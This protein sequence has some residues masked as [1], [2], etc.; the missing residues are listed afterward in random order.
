M[1]KMEPRVAERRRGVSEE[2]A[3]H[4]L[5]WIL[6]AIAVVGLVTVGFWLI[7]S[8]LLSVSTIT[9]EGA[10]KSDPARAISDLGVSVGMPTI[11]VNGGAVRLAVES[12]P[13]VDTAD[14]SV[15][16]PGSVVVTV[17]EHVPLAPATSGNEWM[18]LSADAAVLEPIKAPADDVFVV[19]IDVSGTPIGGSVD[20]PVVQG[21]LVFGSALRPDLAID[22]VMFA[23][24]GGLAAT[25]SGHIV[26]LGRPIELADK[27]LVLAALIDSGLPEGAE[28]NLIAPT[29]PAVTNPQPVVESEQ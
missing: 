25:V 14:V 5:R 20:D 28:I 7:R 12:E 21:A 27:A 2:R 24:S 9:I 29:R 22:A 4:R 13:W 26:R 3:R 19:D 8:P 11:D 6:S 10:D 23:E 16:W 1:T 17:S 15:R 18:I